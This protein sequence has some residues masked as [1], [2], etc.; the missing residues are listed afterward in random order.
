MYLACAWFQDSHREM[1]RIQVELYNAR[2]PLRTRKSLNPKTLRPLVGRVARHNGFK[3]PSSRAHADSVC[4]GL[5][6]WIVFRTF[7]SK[8]ACPQTQRKFDFSVVV[9]GTLDLG[10]KRIRPTQTLF[11]LI[12]LF[13]LSSWLYVINEASDFVPRKLW[14]WPSSE[15]SKTSF[16]NKT[17]GC[18]REDEWLA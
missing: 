18:N 17:T 12:C 11:A 4:F 14:C 2:D 13:E 3:P 8:H 7:C 15:T 1:H 5:W 6:I 9:L 16:A 10:L